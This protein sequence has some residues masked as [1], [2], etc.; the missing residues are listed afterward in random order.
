MSIFFKTCRFKYV[1]SGNLKKNDS[2]GHLVF[3][4]FLLVKG[5]EQTF[6]V[7]IKHLIDFDGNNLS[8]LSE[9]VCFIFHKNEH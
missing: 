3:L 8:Q 9:W 7:M 5:G 4:I 1:V 2:K 6:V